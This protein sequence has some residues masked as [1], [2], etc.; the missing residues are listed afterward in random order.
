MKRYLVAAGLVVGVAMMLL[1]PATAYAPPSGPYVYRSNVYLYTSGLTTQWMCDGEIYNPDAVN[2][3]TD[4]IVTLR[5]R[6]SSSAQL[7]AAVT[8]PAACRVIDSASGENA[9]HFS[10][11]VAAPPVGWSS[12]DLTV[13][14]KAT[15]TPRM[16]IGLN[17]VSDP[18][19]STDSDGF[20]N[21]TFT[22]TNTQGFA[23]TGLVSHG[24]ETEGVTELTASFKDAT[25]NATMLSTVLQPGQTSAW[26]LLVFYNPAD[27]DGTTQIFGYGSCD[28]V[29]YAPLQVYRFYNMRTGTHFYTADPAERDTV[30][31]TLGWLYHLDGVA[32][33]VNAGSPSNMNPLYRFYNKKTGTHFYTASYQEKYAVLQNWPTIFTYEGIAYY[34]AQ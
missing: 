17:N 31:N 15:N 24:Y 9:A 27:S 34:V 8:F 32:Y 5:W 1:T 20:R 13:S 11:A 29:R 12:A 6:D 10:R 18:T 30:I 21:G 19:W 14:G 3:Y 16:V 28:A 23:I 7:G 2:G 25:W 4:V 26:F 22:V 33:T